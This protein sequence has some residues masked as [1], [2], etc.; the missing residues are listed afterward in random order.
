MEA[1]KKQ[2]MPPPGGYKKIQYARVPAKTYMT[3]KFSRARQK[4]F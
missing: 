4:S 3:G 1:A 2:D